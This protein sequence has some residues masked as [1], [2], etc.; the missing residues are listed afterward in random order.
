M[1]DRFSPP[2]EIFSKSS[3]ENTRASSRIKNKEG[4]GKQPL[5]PRG[6]TS[7]PQHKKRR[8]SRGPAERTARRQAGRGGGEPSLQ[9]RAVL[10]A[11]LFWPAPA[12]SFPSGAVEL[13]EDPGA[14]LFTG[15]CLSPS[16]ALASEERRRGRRSLA[17]TADSTDEEGEES[18][19]FSTRQERTR[20]QP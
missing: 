14:S 2:R 10:P 16:Y 17:R 18:D 4:K 6:E 11:G 8:R 19:A 1:A 9:R 5:P 12:S 13:A 7:Q 20:E 15:G 3:A